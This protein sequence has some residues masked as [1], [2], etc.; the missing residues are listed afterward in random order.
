ITVEEYTNYV[1]DVI[2]EALIGEK[3]NLS[4]ASNMEFSPLFFKTGAY[5]KDIKGVSSKT[6]FFV[7]ENNNSNIVF[8]TKYFTYNVDVGDDSFPFDDCT[9]NSSYVTYEKSDVLKPSL[10][11][12]MTRNAKLCF[13]LVD[14]GLGIPGKSGNI[15]FEPEDNFFVY[16]PIKE[17]IKNE[18]GVVSVPFAFCVSI[19]N[20]GEDS[21]FVYDNVRNKLKE[22]WENATENS[23]PSVEGVSLECLDNY[24]NTSSSCDICNDSGS[25]NCL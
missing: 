7:S 3:N 23:V 18:S 15:N 1:T 8:P 17:P 2:E 12:Q 5:M 13:S 21:K 4:S 9:I 16:H 22:E 20:N 14:K 10:C 6:Q 19:V 24:A 11:A 25:K